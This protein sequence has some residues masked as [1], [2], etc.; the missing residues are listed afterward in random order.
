MPKMNVVGIDL[1]TTYSAIAR[2]DRYGQPVAIA[3]AEGEFSTP[4]V[5]HFSDQGPIVG[6]AALRSTVLD[7]QRTVQNAKRELGDPNAGWTIGGRRY[8]PVDISAI[9][10]K[11]LKED[12]QQ[13]IGPITHA[14]ITV[15]AHFDAYRRQL[16]IQAAKKAGLRVL[17]LVN[18]PVAAALCF[19][20][21]EE[22]MIVKELAEDQKL[23]IYDL[24]GGTFDLSLVHYDTENVRVL[25]T[26]GDLKLGGVDWN[27]KIV[28]FVVHCY[29]EK[30]DVDLR[31][32]RRIYQDLALD[33]EEAKRT[34]SNPKRDDVP[35]VVH[36]PKGDLELTLT[37]AQ[38]ESLTG[39]LLQRTR[40][41]TTKLLENT[42]TRWSHINTILSVGG[43]TRMPMVRKMLRELSGVTPNYSLSPDL[44]VAHGAA[45]YA[46]ILLSKTD[47]EM[48]PHV[49]DRLAPI[50]TTNVNSHSLGLMVRDAQNRR[51]NHIIIPRNS[52]LPATAH[53]MV[54][55][56]KANQQR[57]RLQ[58]VE[59]EGASEQDTETICSC[60]I[61]ELPPNLPENSAVE[62]S[63]SY[64]ANGLLE[65]TAR[66][67]DSG[68]L[69]SV[70][71][72]RDKGMSGVAELAPEE[73]KEATE[74]ETPAAGD[75][76]FQTMVEPEAEE[77]FDVEVLP[78]DDDFQTQLEPFEHTIAEA[79]FV[80]AGEDPKTQLARQLEADE[81]RERIRAIREVHRQWIVE[82]FPVIDE[83]SRFDLDSR[84]RD[85]AAKMIQAVRN[86]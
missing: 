82:L 35:L 85:E 17:D 32:H 56:T 70:S 2:L 25:A 83:L 23:L 47:Q 20:L 9:I 44:S 62:V 29:Q 24:G 14:V 66:H 63:L 27:R 31:Q 69:A 55:T 28:D 60:V 50:T 40:R 77:I 26:N 75:E 51:V 81:P 16:T 1:G 49:R 38:F 37:R 10:L 73:V 80:Q 54:G 48:S 53:R 8:T 5:V 7:P 68:L 6:S 79:S 71:L 46:G 39:D 34:L 33:V 84:V 67:L 58:V 18:E 22:G 12:A 42:Q 86:G 30:F 43:S 15:P 19:I 64:Q 74:D 59:G 57:I 61:D 13:Q 78:D 11:K 21:G 72:M 3:N 41:I 52:P 4:S 65:I 76:V 45:L 36:G